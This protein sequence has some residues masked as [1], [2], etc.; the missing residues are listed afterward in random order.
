MNPAVTWYLKDTSK[1]S[2]NEYLEICYSML[3]VCDVVIVLPDSQ[4]S[5]GTNC[6]INYAK[7]EGKR[8]YV[9]DKSDNLHI[10]YHD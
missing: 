8:I 3:S 2:P 4:D 10:L 5:Y 9:L 6:E 1:F 7:Q